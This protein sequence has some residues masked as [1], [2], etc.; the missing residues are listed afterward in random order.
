MPLP[1]DFQRHDARRKLRHKRYWRSRWKRRI[2]LGSLKKKLEEEKE[3][4]K[5]K[6]NKSGRDVGGER[7]ELRKRIEECLR[8]SYLTSNLQLLKADPQWTQSATLPKRV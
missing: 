4:T 2:G 6:K 5:G 1:A 8:L 3:G 7:W